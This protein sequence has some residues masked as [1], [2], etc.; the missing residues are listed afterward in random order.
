MFIS[1]Y[2]SDIRRLEKSE[3]LSV[4]CTEKSRPLEETHFYSNA[5]TSYSLYKQFDI[6]F[7]T[8]NTTNNNTNNKKGNVH[9]LLYIF[10]LY[11]PC[12]TDEV[13]NKVIACLH[14]ELEHFVF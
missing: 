13:L 10:L 5:I 9:I 7:F 3:Y 1:E 8:N 11:L 14:F 6:V 2:I 12:L 4:Y